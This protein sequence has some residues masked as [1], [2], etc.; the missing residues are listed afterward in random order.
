MSGGAHRILLGAVF[1]FA[2]AACSQRR[3]AAAQVESLQENLPTLDQVA[4][5]WR[6]DAY[7]TSADIP[8]HNGNPTPWIISAS[9]QSPSESAE[10]LLVMLEEDGTIT[11]ERVPH[12]IPVVQIE[13]I[14]EEDW[15]L[16]SAEALDMALDAEGRQFLENH[17]DRQC[18]SIVL[19]RTFDQPNRPVVWWLRLGECIGGEPFSRLTVIDALTGEV[20]SRE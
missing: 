2:I 12:S 8:L 7:L 5:S 20:L 14:R 17:S 4:R 11:T 1:I 16:D 18:S 15:N 6:P 3:S 13:P 10:S 19:E 9:F